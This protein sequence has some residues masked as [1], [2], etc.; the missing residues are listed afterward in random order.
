MKSFPIFFLLVFGQ[1]FQKISCKVQPT[2]QRKFFSIKIIARK[3]HNTVPVL[4]HG[5]HSAATNIIFITL[6]PAKGGGLTSSF[7][8]S[9]ALPSTVKL[10]LFEISLFSSATLEVSEPEELERKEGSPSDQT[11]FE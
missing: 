8:G 5:A 7:T 10:D 2:Y 3:D 6:A 4:D 1:P 11:F 9:F